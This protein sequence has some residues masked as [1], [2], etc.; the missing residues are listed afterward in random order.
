V[1]YICFTVKA[2]EFTGGMQKVC[3]RHLLLRTLNFRWCSIQRNLGG[4]AL[5]S[6]WWREIKV[7]LPTSI[8]T[9]SMAFSDPI[10]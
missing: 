2:D 1:L 4:T 3:V 6:H 5:R 8:H 10:E 7:R 9:S